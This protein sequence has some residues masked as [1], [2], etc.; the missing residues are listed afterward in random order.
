MPVHR[1]EVCG[2]EPAVVAHI[3]G[4][5]GF[6]QLCNDLARAEQGRRE[7][8]S[9]RPQLRGEP[10]GRYKLTIAPWWIKQKPR[11]W[12]SKSAADLQ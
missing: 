5:A 6:V 9:A 4:H 11:P 8:F 3:R 12:R 1:G 2:R 10:R 7:L